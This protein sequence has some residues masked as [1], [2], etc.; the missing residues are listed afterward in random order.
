[1]GAVFGAMAETSE[2][3]ELTM[4]ALGG[5]SGLIGRSFD[6]EMVEQQAEFGQISSVPV[7]RPPQISVSAAEDARIMAP[8]HYDPDELVLWSA[9]PGADEEEVVF[10]QPT[11]SQPQNVWEKE[12]PYGEAQVMNRFKAADGIRQ[13]TGSNIARES[14][15]TDGNDEEIEMH[16]YTNYDNNEKL[17]VLETTQANKTS[18][19]ERALQAVGIGTAV[20]SAAYGASKIADH[21]KEKGLTLPGTDYVGPG[22]PINIDA[23]RHGADAI[24]K[25]H[26]ITYDNLSKDSRIKDKTAFAEAVAKA[27]EVAIDQFYDDYQQS[28]RWQSKVGELG[29]RAK[30]TLE[31]LTGP[32]YPTQQEEDAHHEDMPAVELPSAKKR[33]P[34]SDGF[35][36]GEFDNVP[37]NQEEVKAKKE[38]T[39]KGETWNKKNWAKIKAI[40]KQK[41]FNKA[42]VAAADKAEAEYN[43]EK[44]SSSTDAATEKNS[45]TETTET[46]Q[47]TETTT[48]EMEHRR[49]EEPAGAEPM[50]TAT[51]GPAGVSSSSR[52]GHGGGAPQGNNPGSGESMPARAGFVK[53]T[54]RTFEHVY[55][56]R[57]WGKNW[58][59]NTEL[60]TLDLTQ[61]IDN[62]VDTSL[63]YI[64]VENL[65]FYLNPAEFADLPIHAVV[66]HVEVSIEN[67]GIT[68]SFETGSTVSST[69][70]THFYCDAVMA[71]NLHKVCAVRPK[72]VEFTAGTVEQSGTQDV[73][74][75]L[76]DMWN[77]NRDFSDYAMNV[78]CRDNPFYA[79]IGWREWDIRAAADD[80]TA[81]SFF[82]TGA[83]SFDR[84]LTKMNAH[85]TVGN[86][87]YNYS[88]SPKDGTINRP[89]CAK[90]LGSTGVA[91]HLGKVNNFHDQINSFTQDDSADFTQNLNTPW[92]GIQSG[93]SV[94]NLIDGKYLGSLGN[95]SNTNRTNFRHQFIEKANL[96]GDVLHD[97]FHMNYQQPPCLLGIMPV[98]ANSP[99]SLNASPIN[100]SMMLRIRTKITIEQP[101]GHT[102]FYERFRV[103]P[104][105]TNY[106]SKLGPQSLLSTSSDILSSVACYSVWPFKNINFVT[107]S[108]DVRKLTD[109][110]TSGDAKEKDISTRV[111]GLTSECTSVPRRRYNTRSSVINNEVRKGKVVKKDLMKIL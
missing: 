81:S 55:T 103:L 53:G 94:G 105:T 74:A 95:L 89:M 12:D 68:S 36:P 26:D 63:A 34:N 69:A 47:P 52:A 73:T 98:Y 61:S 64:P 82:R 45:T 35:E 101:S 84:F 41:A 38:A 44:A 9:N 42:A 62:I 24:A 25:E 7:A 88:Y 43:K 23:P 8:V 90:P 108:D 80:E 109:T 33:K 85:E 54:V 100:C 111:G 79:R 77:L 3:E 96:R 70:S 1:M 32:L 107:G 19:T 97:S 39:K 27:D 104:P 50:D 15:T 22:N 66:K 76:L 6:E 58:V 28:G 20:G 92:A 4:T 14:Y 65:G 29:L 11:P 16:D 48:S 46:G 83:P 13:R 10:Q 56:T 59:Y 99:G 87:I 17:R 21:V 93:S 72:Y 31:K 91:Y 75:E 110:N 57:T 2:E 60:N 37:S 86:V 5:G 71:N 102:N 51:A 30:S 67:L 78:L 18:T 49:Q 40:Q 106:A